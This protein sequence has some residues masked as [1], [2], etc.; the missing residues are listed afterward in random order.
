MVLSR[1]WHC[2]GEGG[3]GGGGAVAWRTRAPMMMKRASTATHWLHAKARP[4][5]WWHHRPAGRSLSGRLQ[6]MGG[7]CVRARLPFRLSSF[8]SCQRKPWACSP[9]RGALHQTAT[10]WLALTHGGLSMHACM[11]VHQCCVAL[12][13]LRPVRPRHAICHHGCRRFASPAAVAWPCASA[14]SKHA[15]F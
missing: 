1:W 5:I 14:R 7:A 15:Q 10:C 4:G 11:N 8:C 12:L 6:R 13:E 2:L 3:G 9:R